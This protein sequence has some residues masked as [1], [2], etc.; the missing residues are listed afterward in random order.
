[1]ATSLCEQCG[2]CCD[3]TLF[4]FVSLSEE[5]A[6]RLAARDL[7]I[8]VRR[9]RPALLQRCAALEGTLCRVYEERPAACRAY[10]CMLLIQER[11]GELGHAEAVAHIAQA[12][13]LL[14]RLGAVVGPV[15][16]HEARAMRAEGALSD[17]G[18]ACVDALEA[19]LLR[20]FRGRHTH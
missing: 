14:A 5:D 16:A 8:G 17:E 15:T 12:K 2:L 11:E 7:A 4:G 20:V 3:G 19:F 10:E 18:R 9:E 6:K 13:A 1:M